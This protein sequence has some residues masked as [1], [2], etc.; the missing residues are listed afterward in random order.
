MP[1]VSVILV[2]QRN[3]SL[4]FMPLPLEHRHIRLEGDAD[5]ALEQVRRYFDEKWRSTVHALRWLHPEQMLIP[6]NGETEV[7]VL[8]VDATGQLPIADGSADISTHN[9]RNPDIDPL[10][11]AAILPSPCQPWSNPDWLTAM[12]EWIAA[13]FST[14][15]VTRIAQIRVCFHGAVLKL[16]GPGGNWFLKTVHSAFASE[17]GLLQVLAKCLPGACPSVL[18]LSPDPNTHITSEVL[19]RPLRVIH[20]PMEWKAALRQVANLQRESTRHIAAIRA[21]GAPFQSFTDFATRLEETIARLLEMQRNA[22]NQLATE[23]LDRFGFLIENARR[24]C[25]VLARCNLPEA[26]VPAISKKAISFAPAEE[27][28]Y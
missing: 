22:P 8:H 24:D 20:D 17:V 2:K 4:Q 7:L 16:Q 19:G 14:N 18:S 10:V 1:T 6:G 26:L 23:D 25:D 28:R 3:G 13:T 9:Q 15:C 11:C 5:N 12:S 27:T 21:T